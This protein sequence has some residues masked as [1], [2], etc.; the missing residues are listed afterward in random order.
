MPLKVTC[1]N[2][3]CGA[4][5]EVPDEEAGTVVACPKC[6]EPVEVPGG[7]ETAEVQRSDGRKGVAH[8]A[9]LRC[10]NCGALLGVRDAVCPK[11]GADVRT[12]AAMQ[13]RKAKKRMPLVPIAIGGGIVVALAIL[14]GLILLAVKLASGGKEEAEQGKPA[15]QQ[16]VVA[17]VAAPEKE[18]PKP[19]FQLP[20]ELLGELPA[21]EERAKQAVSAYLERLK[22]TLAHVR[23]DTPEQ[24]ARRW[25]DLYAFCRDNGLN[26]E[27]ELCWY[28]AVRLDPSDPEVNATLGRTETFEGVPVLPEQ[29]QF[30]ES[31]QPEVR[32]V[33]HDPQLARHAV[34]L[35]STRRP[36]PPGGTV[37]LTPA[38][39][40][41]LIEIISDDSTAR[42]IERIALPAHRGLV[43]TVELKDPVLLGTVP[44]AELEK[45]FAAVRQGQTVEGVRLEPAPQGSGVLSASAGKLSVVGMNQAPLK[46]QVAGGGRYLDVFG[47]IRIGDPYGDEGQRVLH[48]GAGAPLRLSLDVAARRAALDTGYYYVLHVDLADRLW[49]ALAVAD[50]DFG[51]EWARR[52]LS[53]RFEDVELANNEAE[54]S[55]K[56]LGPWQATARA[57]D[58]MNRLRRQLMDELQLQDR[59]AALADGLDKTRVLGVQ[60]RLKHLGLNWPR[61][62]KALAQLTGDYH[63][64][65]LGQIDQMGTE[66]ETPQ[67]Q[68]PRGPRR[69]P[70]GYAALGFAPRAAATPTKSEFEPSELGLTKQERLYVRM[71]ALALLPASVAIQQVQAAW[72][73]LDKE[74]RTAA[75]A[76]LDRIGGSQVVYYLG[77]LSRAA[78]KPDVIM[79]ALLSL[80]AVGTPQALTYCDAP[81]V[82]PQVKAASLAAKALAGDPDAL[83][84][85]PAFLKSADSSQR[86]AFVQ[87]ASQI[88]T[89]ATVLVL[90]DLIDVVS[91]ADSQKRIADALTRI[92]GHTCMAQLVRLMKKSNQLWPDMLE[93][94]AP[95]EA[96][97]LVRRVGHAIANNPDEKAM[98]WLDR[99]APQAALAYCK[100]AAINQGKVAAL[101]HLALKGSAEALRAAA[102]A[103]GRTTLA[104][105]D[106]LRQDWFVRRGERW[107]WQQG[108]DTA[109]ATEFLKQAF[110]TGGN[111]KVRLAAAEL[112]VR[113]GEKPDAEALLALAAEEEKKEQAAPP[114]GRGPR[115]GPPRGMRMGP[116]PGVRRGPPAGIPMGPGAAAP[117]KPEQYKPSKF[118]EPV[119]TPLAPVGEKL[120]AKT[121]LY[122]LYVLSQ[123]ADEQASA[124][125]RELVS[126][127]RDL[128][129]RAAGMRALADIGGEANLAFLRDGATQTKASYESA[130]DLLS[131]LQNRLAALRALGAAGDTDFVP[132]LLDIL[133]EQPPPAESVNKAGDDY[134]ELSGW[135]QLRLRAGACDCLAALCRHKQLI[136]LTG[137]STLQR[138]FVQTLVGLL[139]QPGSK[140][141]SLEDA[142]KNLIAHAVRA[143]GRCASFYDADV[144]L[145]LRQLAMS[146][147]QPEQARRPM[148][149]RGFRPTGPMA[150]PSR[151]ARTE[152]PKVPVLKLR[153]ALQDAVV[154]M[155]VRGDGV[156]IFGQVPGLVPTSGKATAELQSLLLELAEAPTPELVVLVNMVFGTLDVPTKEELFERLSGSTVAYG[157]DYARLVLKMV[158]EPTARYRVDLDALAGGAPVDRK[159]LLDSL[160]ELLAEDNWQLEQGPDGTVVATTETPERAGAGP[161]AGGPPPGVGGPPP[162]VREEMMRAGPP[163]GPPGPMGPFGPPGFAR[164][165]KPEE[166]Y[167]RHGDRRKTDWTYTITKLG[168]TAQRMAAGWSRAQSLF[169][170]GVSYLGSIFEA[171]SLV[172]CPDYGPAI[173]ALYAEKA[174]SERKKIIKALQDLVAPPPPSTSQSVPGPGMTAPGAPGPGFRAP[175]PPAGRGGMPGAEGVSL[176]TR[177]AAV[178]ALS[179]IGGDEAKK[180]LLTT[181]VGPPVPQTPFPGMGP[182]VMGP[183]P[184]VR[185]G[186]GT[187]GPPPGVRGGPGMVRGGPPGMPGP[188]MPG[189]GPTEMLGGGKYAARALGMLGAS[190]LLRNALNAAGCQF[191]QH[192]AVAVQKAALEG[193]AY[194]PAEQHPVAILEELLRLAG[195]PELRKATA[196]AIQTALRRMGLAAA[197]AKAG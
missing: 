16:A 60:D 110:M 69:G 40:Q 95:E 164:P 133:T 78:G 140:L 108:V 196:E 19:K 159:A 11:C 31:L 142:R 82:L 73:E 126:G 125:L 145:V 97:L 146:V 166:V 117:A 185:G 131:T 168:L 137:D 23:T 80:G 132:R 181:L 2:P 171:E 92:G 74:A 184:G 121:Q 157:A 134:P 35:G 89:P 65:I 104:L 103:A 118:E 66:A 182:G 112:L 56:L 115:R 167:I 84:Q 4:V 156:S 120:E 77:N 174:P 63:E 100:A 153:T 72:P 43:C 144:E 163:G 149:T 152:K 150:R 191:F 148:M 194:L 176:S 136:E 28:S 88:E 138:Q 127:Y 128:Q 187:M 12:G 169:A 67:Q 113:A 173:A 49:E 41:A 44:Y 105:L 7:G 178:S 83:Q 48:P 188:G 57:F 160:S 46:M 29:K 1:E 32:V 33:N 79:M 154:H 96:T 183:P 180:A 175:G 51:S 8:P 162:W 93:R 17:S 50:G 45:V 9:R 155:A 39:G 114:G 52:R 25:A 26:S 193:L 85:V 172:E 99:V 186:P 109:A 24:M 10:P 129:L 38:P 195:T 165:T 122:A 179:R 143:L 141:P 81:A 116:P 119:R 27:A 102:E 101:R 192:D 62:R 75:L 87:F 34:R 6:G 18:K 3:N 47:T 123:V 64:A 147:R 106:E 15:A 71:R 30:L 54:A 135:W 161:R 111:P 86:S 94:I 158:K 177:R 98:R 20:E 76:S 130:D 190:E 58:Q 5:F 36:L 21:R 59:A 13:V 70:T 55:G 91:D 151:R 107:A 124:R 197:E 189:V 139:K 53:E 68:G 22:E 14:V 61:F 90:A 42:A 37:T 170:G